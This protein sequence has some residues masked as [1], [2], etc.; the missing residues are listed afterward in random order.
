MKNIPQKIYLALGLPG[1]EHDDIDF[2]ELHEVTWCQDKISPTDPE[3][4]L[5]SPRG[6]IS[7]PEFAERLLELFKVNGTSIQYLKD[8]CIKL[9][10]PVKGSAEMVQIVIDTSTGHVIRTE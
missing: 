3:Y 7:Q 6:Q 5:V 1:T 10:L 8:S 4:R 9:S 2:N